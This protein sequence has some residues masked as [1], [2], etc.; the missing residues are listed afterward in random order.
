MKDIQK[1]L[2]RFLPEEKTPSEDRLVM[3]C[4]GIF[5]IAITLLVLDIGTSVE[6]SHDI[7]AVLESLVAPTISYMITFLILATYWRFH[8][9]LM[10]VVQRLD[11][12]FT[13][14]T[15]LFLFFI[16][17][18]P[19]TS[20]LIGADGGDK[21]IVT[22]YT[23][24]LSG[25]GFSAFALWFY[26]THKH[27]L[28]SPD[29]PQAEINTRMIALL[30]NPLIYCASLLLLFVVPEDQAYLICFSWSLIGFTQRGVRY[31][32]QRWLARPVHALIHHEHEESATSTPSEQKVPETPAALPA[33]EEESR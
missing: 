12:P 16:A 3:L 2:Q 10:Q 4:D 29:L 33:Q 28:V 6:A 25:C 5:A 17:L 27:R 22:I 7:N 23:L 9:N 31:V 32:Y 11:G 30:L 26:A 1:Q 14:L 21:A 15:F 20:K 24:G 18:F 8:R 13:S 19:A